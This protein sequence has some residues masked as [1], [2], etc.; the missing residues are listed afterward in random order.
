MQCGIDIMCSGITRRFQ[1]TVFK[2]PALA[3]L[4][5]KPERGHLPDLA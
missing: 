3:G 5:L 1:A 4:A 2:V